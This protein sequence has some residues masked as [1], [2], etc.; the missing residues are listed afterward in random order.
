MA[1]HILWE[2][3]SSI[4]IMCERANWKTCPQHKHLT[5]K[6]PLVAP[7]A[8]EYEEAKN[9]TDYAAPKFQTVDELSDQWQLNL[10]R[11][12]YVDFGD[13]AYRLAD[14]GVS[15]EPFKIY[16]SLYDLPD[17]KREVLEEEL[18]V[19]VDG[20][21]YSLDEYGE[22]EASFPD[23]LGAEYMNLDEWTVESLEGLTVS[24]YASNRSGKGEI[25]NQEIENIFQEGGCAVYALA[26]KELNPEYNIAVDIWECDGENMYNH[27]FCV[28]A[29]T[30]RAYDSRGEFESAEALLDYKSDS[31]YNGYVHE[32]SE[33]YTDKGYTFWDIEQTKFR[34]K[35]GEFTFDDNPKDIA[36]IKKLITGFKPRI[37]L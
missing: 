34:I 35:T 4:P 36:I 28:D 16:E 6:Q 8:L 20:V 12:G 9:V 13:V 29:K 2:S 7:V 10:K 22:V 19:V 31:G 33:F 37:T 30:G 24:E 18:F 23:P 17:D 26:L 1:S 3:N 27:V 11:D 25:L 5:D 21:G 14:D 32:N 15:L